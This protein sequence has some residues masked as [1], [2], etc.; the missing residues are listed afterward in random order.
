MK[1]IIS[2]YAKGKFNISD[3]EVLCKPSYISECIEPDAIFNGSFLIEFSGG[4]TKGCVFSTNRRMTLEKDKFLAEKIELKYSFCGLGLKEGDIIQGDFVILS[5]AGEWHIPYTITVQL[6]N[7]VTEYGKIRNCEIFAALATADREEAYKVFCSR[8]FLNTLK[9]GDAKYNTLYKALTKDGFS[10]DAMDEF[11]SAVRGL[12]YNAAMDAAS[13]STSARRKKKNNQEKTIE[14]DRII[15]LYELF[16]DFRC[17]KTTTKAWI[18]KTRALL[19]EQ[20]GM[21]NDTGFYSLYYVHTLIIEGKSDEAKEKLDELSE[22]IAAITARARL[23]AYYLYLSTLINMSE[24]FINLNCKR[25]WELYKKNNDDPF[26]LWILF[27]MEKKFLENADMKCEMAESLYER[28]IVSPLILMEIALIYRRNPSLCAELSQF[29]IQVLLF[30]A[31]NNLLTKEL[32]DMI[33]H[34]AVLSSV[35]DMRIYLLLVKCYEALESRECLQTI[36]HYLIRNSKSE[37][38]FFKWFELGIEQ[39]LRIARL[40]DYY[41]Y[42]VKEDM[43]KPLP[44]K[45]LQYFKFNMEIEY[46]KKSYLF[47]NLYRFRE[48]I[49]SQYEEYKEDIEQFIIQQLKLGRINRHLAY[50]YSEL[51]DESYINEENAKQ[52]TNL[53]FSYHAKELPTWASSVVV[54]DPLFVSHKEYVIKNAEAVVYIYSDSSCVLLRDGN[55][56]HFIKNTAGWS[57]WFENSRLLAVCEKYCPTHIGILLGR[58]D[59]LLRGEDS[60]WLQTI[61]EILHHP[62]L[63]YLGKEAILQRLFNSFYEKEDR[64]ALEKLLEIREAYPEYLKTGDNHLNVFLML[65]YYEEAFAYSVKYGCEHILAAKL[66]PMCDYIISQEEFAYDDELY[67][68]TAEIFKRDKYSES[69]LKYLM[70]Y[71]KGDN[72]FL[73]KLMDACRNFSMDSAAIEERLLIQ[74]L[75]CG[76]IPE[77]IYE[78]YVDY[79]MHGANHELKNAFISYISHEEIA[80]GRIVDA[81]FLEC[82]NRH[83]SHD[84]HLP[85]VCKILW[86]KAFSNGAFDDEELADRILDEFEQNDRFFEFYQRLPARLRDKYLL[87]NKLVIECRAAVASDLN[88]YYSL[89]EK[90]GFIR[91][92]MAEVYPGVYATVLPVFTDEEL[93]YYISS[94]NGTKA[95][96]IKCERTKRELMS[97]KT[98]GRYGWL[99]RILSQTSYEEKEKDLIEFLREDLLNSKLFSK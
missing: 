28:G 55:K 79:D 18:I 86:L 11:L 51:L 60:Q 3:S 89:D 62:D 66:V 9:S 41:L 31:R 13:G 82:L 74:S 29:N 69:M 64:E 47:A 94:Q 90:E 61:D 25:I 10:Y 72:E 44:E 45:V 43:Q 1:E 78:M 99:D 59:K 15:C 6:D 37:N 19:S 42:S 84:C 80:K 58:C 23:Y 27:M 52:L 97:D 34:K 48:S 33:F 53:L 65:N 50:L 81:R 16:L 76:Q 87:S 24:P 96:I 92:H 49:P 98:R 83:I 71:V 75:F 7:A 32:Y 95:S 20:M 26:I 73:N 68:L 88:C 56:K 93:L 39:D 77:N 46:N 36:C 4:R 38:R 22:N 21:K 67:R 63:S 12:D 70:M 2:A 91:K 85:D 8:K 17:M 40:Y 30:A 14:M 35:F 54:C 5:E 57:H